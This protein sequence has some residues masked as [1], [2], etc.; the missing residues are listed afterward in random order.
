MSTTSPRPEMDALLGAYVLDAVDVDER[1]LIDAYLDENPSARDEVDDLLETVALLA[2]APLGD[3]SAPPELWDRIEAELD[4][5]PTD[6]LAARRSRRSRP[7]VWIATAVA[8]V[9]TAA[10]IVLALQVVSL[11]RDLDHAKQPTAANLEANFDRAA[12]VRGAREVTLHSTRG[13]ARVVL[14]PDGHGYIVNDDLPALRAD[15]TYQLWAFVGTEPRII[16]AGVL[17][18]DPRAASFTVNGPVKTLAM[19]IERRGGA[20]QPTQQPF[21]TANLS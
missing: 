11:N 7:V 21:T 14:L 12:K 18:S 10:A 6:E 8:A 20:P 9:A 2:S 19:T 4:G 5:A 3:T 13:D 16:S 15:E 17:G 1:A